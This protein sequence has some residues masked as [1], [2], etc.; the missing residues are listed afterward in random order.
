MRKGRKEILKTDLQIKKVALIKTILSII[1]VDVLVA[2]LFYFLETISIEGP[3]LIWKFYFR[4]LA[5]VDIVLFF[6][7]YTMAKSD[8]EMKRSKIFVKKYLSTEEGVEVVPIKV[9]NYTNFIMNLTDIAKFYAI[10]ETNNKMVIIHIKFNNEK[11]K[12]F[13][14]Q[15]EL[16]NFTKYYKIKE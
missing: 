11:E 13:F 4:I 8:E 16:Y 3:P 1:I 10:I 7:Y 2:V 6:Y 15:I 12:R 9:N 5:I 14:E